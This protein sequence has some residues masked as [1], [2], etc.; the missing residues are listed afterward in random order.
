MCGGPSPLADGLERRRP[1]SPTEA[2][3]SFEIA[4]GFVLELAAAEPAVTDPIAATF[5]ENGRLY[6][7][8]MRGYPFD[9]PAGAAPQGRIRLLEDKDGDGLFESSRVFADRLQWPSGIACWKSGIFVSAAPDIVYLRDTTGDGVANMRRTVFSGFGTGKSED[10]VNN[11][12]WG[13][14]HWIYGAS[15]YNGGVVRH[16]QRSEA[17]GVPLASNDFR[18]DP[19]TETFQAVEGTGGDF[20]NAFDDWG[21]RFGS[22]S[23]NPV[24]HAVFPLEHV[25]EGMEPPELAARIFESERLV[26][27]ISAPEPWRAARK[28][29]W[30]RWVDTTHE[31]RAR[32]FPAEELALQG[33]YTG[34]AG[35]GI[36]RGAAYSP[37]YRGNAFSPEPAG[38]LVVR[39]ILERSGVTFR[40]RRA[41]AGREFLASSDSWSRP[42][43]FA[44]GP[45]GCL[46]MLDMYREVI[47]DPSAI[48]DEILDHLDYSSG[49]EM[50]RIYRI[51]PEG[52]APG[53]PPRLGTA[54]VAELVGALEHESGWWRS[55]AQ[56]LLYERRDGAAAPL[57][58]GLL[59]TSSKPRSRLHALWALDGLGELDERTLLEALG[60][61]HAAVRQAAVRLSARAP[62]L[63][64]GLRAQIRSMASDES[65]PVRFRVAL[66]VAELHASGGAEVLASILSRDADDPW[67]RT[68]VLSAAGQNS[69]TLLAA[70]LEN[71]Q[72]VE[73]PRSHAA[74]KQLAANVAATG[75]SESMRS[76]LD[77]AGN[78]GEAERTRARIAITAGIA[79]G[80]ERAGS[81]LRSLRNDRPSPE[82]W[83]GIERVLAQAPRV[84]GDRASPTLD[85]R[86]D[87]IE[88][89]TLAAPGTALEALEPILSPD[90]PVRVQLA[91]IRSLGAHRGPAVGRAIVDGW[92]GYSPAVRR[93]ALEALFGRQERL[94]P[95]LS[96]LETGAVVPSQLDPARRAALQNHRQAAIRESARAVLGSS[97]VLIRREVMERYGSAIRAPG[98]PTRGARV[99]ERECATCHRLG[100]TGHSVG[101]DLRERAASP[102]EE[103]LADIVDP[104][105]SLQS[106]FVNYR[107][108]TT[109]G[110]VVTG[111]LARE[112]PVSVTLRRGE[113]IEDRVPRSKVESLTSM[114][115]SLM[116]EGLEDAIRPGEMADLLRF[117][118]SQAR[119]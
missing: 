107:L 115:L 26:Y 63:G 48:P 104:N 4:D 45:D 65:A 73:D 22:N 98:D 59:A 30:S 66:A 93:E 83:S 88:L 21:N 96:A 44:N 35:L 85:E 62:V 61:E 25:V 86:I 102:R 23:G 81:S 31:M 10:I 119:R 90:E 19:L 28:N 87:A 11:L 6:V 50:G 103:L 49:R 71:R 55:T 75:S 69:V 40:A 12:K 94:G 89:L 18:F 70:L 78:L 117:I 101:P 38:N 58:R 33:H 100:G 42:V 92:R 17:D 27:P 64:A 82:L 53:P 76:M 112:S 24:I 32:R 97:E 39:S 54:S 67:I 118:Q 46:Y 9:P 47:E 68:A 108:D 105:R 52:F 111:I 36:Y 56:R 34:G 80:L 60:D 91:A 109:D 29:H 110:Q 43:N 106:N 2:V 57:L 1:L 3:R 16:A 20:G 72:F 37:E 51:V 14:D 74:V 116:P 95:F 41:T 5:D 8:E 113:G 15:S 114:G 84:A 7:A 13:P 77:L 99:F 79:A